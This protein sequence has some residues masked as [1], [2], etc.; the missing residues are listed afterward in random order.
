MHV[1]QATRVRP[2]THKYESKTRIVPILMSFFFLRLYDARSDGGEGEAYI[3]I[4]AAP[5]ASDFM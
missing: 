2:H 3:I 1:A 5:R 4:I